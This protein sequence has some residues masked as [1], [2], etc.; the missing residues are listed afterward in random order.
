[1]VSIPDEHVVVFDVNVYLDV[2][3]RLGPPITWDRF[4]TEA[5]AIA[6]NYVPTHDGRGGDSVVALYYC[7]SGEFVPGQPLSVWTS[8]HIENLIHRKAT[9]TPDADHP[10]DR[11]L[12]WSEE[13]ATEILANLHDELVWECGRGDL[14]HVDAPYGPP[15]LG[16]ED[17]LVLR[18]AL[19]AGNHPN[20]LRYC[21]TNDRRLRDIGDP[22][23]R[24]TVLQPHQWV[25]TV[26]KSRQV[27]AGFTPLSYRPRQG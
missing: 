23:G 13:Q 9:Q 24:V 8:N 12:G 27:A 22:D 6:S 21:V 17:G 10:D 18:T 19:D 15:E 26:R 14:V 25:Q 1:L 2:A 11:G 20:D 7:L 4:T 3:E 5:A 16:R